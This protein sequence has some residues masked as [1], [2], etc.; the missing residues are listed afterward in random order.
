MEERDD[1]GIFAAERLLKKR[2]RK[3]RREYLVKWLGY[4]SKYNTWEPENNILDERLFQQF[5]LRQRT[6]TSSSDSVR[7][8]NFNDGQT[9]RMLTDV[10]PKDK[11]HKFGGEAKFHDPKRCFE[12]VITP[13]VRSGYRNDVGECLTPRRGNQDV[14]NP[15]HERFVKADTDLLRE[16][17]YGS[18]N[19]TGTPVECKTVEIENKLTNSINKTTASEQK[20]LTC[21][22]I[23]A[24]LKKNDERANFNAD[25][26]NDEANVTSTLLKRKRPEDL[27]TDTTSGVFETSTKDGEKFAKNRK[28]HSCS[29]S[30][31][32]S[33]DENQESIKQ[34]PS[35]DSGVFFDSD[36][37]PISPVT[38]SG[39]FL[40]KSPLITPW[41]PLY[42]VPYDKTSPTAGLS[43][44]IYSVSHPTSMLPGLSCCESP[45]GYQQSPFHYLMVDRTGCVVRPRAWELN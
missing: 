26:C 14:L 45:Y 42:Y 2:I 22:T 31:T 30:S 43:D 16:R 5:Q 8:S 40:W 35:R 4:S 23:D 24:I 13:E 25:K 41:Y 15:N 44:G 10:D 34:S 27:K 21:F 9:T 37:S 1:Q 17:R 19:G 11:E 36:A 3:G 6:K 32:S 20:A 7:A 12:E 38:S 18:D 28:Y 39:N 29:A 33:F